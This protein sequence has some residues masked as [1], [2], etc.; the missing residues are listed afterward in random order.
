MKLLLK[1]NLIFLLIFAGGLA[2]IG[3]VSWMLLERNAREEIAQSAGLSVNEFTAESS[4]DTA[5]VSANWR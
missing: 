2:A 1:F 5:M 3:Q 4:V